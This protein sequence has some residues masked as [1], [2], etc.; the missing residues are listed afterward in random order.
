MLNIAEEPTDAFRCY[1]AEF[2][3]RQAERMLS[4]DVVGKVARF[5]SRKAADES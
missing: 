3:L 1:L 2:A 5:Q 4:P